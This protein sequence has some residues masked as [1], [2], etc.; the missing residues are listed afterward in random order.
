MPDGFLLSTVIV[1]SLWALTIVAIAKRT[2]NMF[3]FMLKFL[4]HSGPATEVDTDT[5]VVNHHVHA[6]VV[7]VASSRLAFTVQYL[8]AH[9]LDIGNTLERLQ[10]VTAI[11]T[12][13]KEMDVILLHIVLNPLGC[14]HFGRKVGEY[15]QVG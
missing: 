6:S 11:M 13:K 3:L 8:A 15:Q 10:I 7:T 9:V 14:V 1:Y 2:N 12:G 4:F 5:L